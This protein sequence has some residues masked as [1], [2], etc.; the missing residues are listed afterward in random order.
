MLASATFW[1]FCCKHGL[2][3]TQNDWQ[4]WLCD[5]SRAH[6]LRFRSGLGPTRTP[7]GELTALPKPHS[8]FKGEI[9]LSKRG[10]DVKE[11]KGGEERAGKGG[12][13]G[14]RKVGRGD[15]PP[16][17]KFWTCPC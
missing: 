9:L 11:R 12:I 15:G 5:S 2:Q 17:A 13:G 10:G 3:D 16:N 6:Q 8:W 1:S 14:I 4:K 7:L